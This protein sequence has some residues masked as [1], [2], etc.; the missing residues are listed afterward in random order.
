MCHRQLR[1]VKST[2]CGHLTFTGETNIDCRSRH[3]HLSTA[4]PPSCGSPRAPCNCKRYYGQP[5]RIVTNE[6]GLQCPANNSRDLTIHH[7]W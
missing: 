5:Q 1:F 6:V 7:D 3:C 4:H 2:A